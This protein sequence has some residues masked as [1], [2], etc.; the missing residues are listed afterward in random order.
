MLRAP[1]WRSWTLTL[2]LCKLYN[3]SNLLK[4]CVIEHSCSD[5][6][7][8][9]AAPNCHGKS[10]Y[11]C[12]MKWFSVT[13]ETTAGLLRHRSPHS[14]C[15]IYLWSTSH[16]ICQ[17]TLETHWMPSFSKSVFDFAIWVTREDCGDLCLRDCVKNLLQCLS[18][19]LNR[20]WEPSFYYYSM[21]H[22]TV[23][24]VWKGHWN[25]PCPHFIDL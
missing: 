24:Q 20:T 15:V 2:Y 17:H 10:K 13:I 22:L 14:G 5:L 1:I 7:V 19:R 11:G 16:R 25:S 12:D 18:V 6:R 21:W 4:L 23:W 8:K 9:I 3:F